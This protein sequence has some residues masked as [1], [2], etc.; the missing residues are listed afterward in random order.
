MQDLINIIEQI[1]TKNK[2]AVL[3]SCHSGG[4]VL[5]NVPVIDIDEMVEHFVGRGFAVLA[6]CGA[7]QF[8]GFNEDREISLYTSFVCDA[9]TSR[10]LIKKGKKSLETINEAIFRFAEISNRKKGR[11][12]QQP[13]F[14]SSIGGTIFF[15]VEEYNPYKIAKIYEEIR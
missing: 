3:D 14:R 4:F 5:D 11:N 13:I 7:E 9:L 2:I 15:D 1:Q 6:S 10:F 12:F 8:S